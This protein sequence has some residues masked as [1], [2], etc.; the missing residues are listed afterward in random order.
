MLGISV[1]RSLSPEHL[2]VINAMEKLTENISDIML[3]E[4]DVILSLSAISQYETNAENLEI[5]IMTLGEK[6]LEK[7]S[8]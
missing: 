2:N 1:P 6:V 8:N 5:T 3:Y 4:T 7:L